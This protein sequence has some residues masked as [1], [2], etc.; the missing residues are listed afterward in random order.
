ME[1]DEFND[2]QLQNMSKE[3]IIKKYKS[4]VK[5][6]TEQ[7][8]S[9]KSLVEQ[10]KS[11]DKKG[12]E[13]DF[14][15]SQ[16]MK[17]KFYVVKKEIYEKFDDEQN[18][19]KDVSSKQTTDKAHLDAMY[20]KFKEY[21]NQI[22]IGQGQTDMDVDSED[23][24]DGQTKKGIFLQTKEIDEIIQHK[25]GS[26]LGINEFLDAFG[27]AIRNNINQNWTKDQRIAFKNNLE[28]MYDTE[29]K[30]IFYGELPEHIIQL[31][32]DIILSNAL[33]KVYNSDE[34]ALDY[35]I[36]MKSQNYSL[37]PLGKGI[38]FKNP[39]NNKDY[40]F[41]K[42]YIKKRIIN[43]V[44][45]LNAYYKVVQ[46]FVTDTITIDSLK[47]KIAEIIDKTNFY[48]CDLPK[49]VL[50][51]T[52][53]NGD[54]FITGKFLQES[55]HHSN[56][57]KFYNFIGN[58]KIFLTILHEIAH[59]LQY[60]IRSEVNKNDNYFIKT[61]YFK[62]EGDYTFQIVENIKVDDREDFCDLKKV[63]EMDNKSL[64]RIKSYEN[65]HGIKTRCESGDFFDDEIYLG[66]QQKQVTISTGK[67]LLLSTCENYNN[68]I[69]I[70][71]YIL[72]NAN[73]S[74]E[75]EKNSSYK[76]VDDENVY[77]YHSYIRKNA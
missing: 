7:N 10:N 20:E 22:N 58:S 77:C 55:F 59:K 45:I 54:I 32:M 57:F 23:S 56:K 3:L 64:E 73:D 15:I 14:E 60:T 28:H 24:D 50:G 30:N 49:R 67:F 37:N 42:T 74:R 72:S 47:R 9:L 11:L 18:T 29:I 41:D 62:K 17:E 35:L 40:L 63:S 6:F 5:T 52:I 8:N 1:V 69:K 75:R 48:F 26:N 43:N 53:C 34:K 65:L 44:G 4:L 31:K 39:N 76:L 33:T 19:T 71:N 16:L 36:I 61:F 13:K 2:E 68:F 12:Q 51:I 66:K 38:L 25:F 27:K 70:M 21:I 46:K